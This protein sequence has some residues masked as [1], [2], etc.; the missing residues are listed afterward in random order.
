[1]ENKKENTLDGVLITALGCAVIGGLH[2]LADRSLF[3]II[4]FGTTAIGII[5]FYILRQ[6][7][8]KSTETLEENIC[9]RLK[10]SGFQYEKKEGDLFVVKNENRFQVQLADTYNRRIKHLYIY[11]KF[12]DDNANKVNMDGW[13]RASN[14]IN[15]RNTETIFVTL[16]DHF[17]CCYQTA[18]GNSKDFMKEFNFAYERIGE[19]MDDYNKLFPYLE[20]DYPNHTESQTSIGFRQ[21]EP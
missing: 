12:K 19:A 14:A 1:M 10:K 21:N 8:W 4:L 5:V 18:I 7:I 6:T 13:G 20:R 9:K 17:C 16:E 2:Y 3:T 11:Y 15:V